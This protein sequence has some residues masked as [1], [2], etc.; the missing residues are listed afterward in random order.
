MASSYLT[1]TP[2]SSGNRRKFTFSAWVRFNL[3]ELAN[4]SRI[5]SCGSAT[6]AWVSAY[7]NSNYS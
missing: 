1:R 7:I 2:S 3:N 6:S 4:N 5:F